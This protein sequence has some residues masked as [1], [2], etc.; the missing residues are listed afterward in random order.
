MT[1]TTI[2]LIV[3]LPFSA[4]ACERYLAIFMPFRYK[5]WATP[6]KVRLVLLLCLLYPI[7]LL[8]PPMATRNTWQ[9]TL[10]CLVIA[11]YPPWLMDIIVG[12]VFIC[13]VIMMI[14]YIQII[15]MSMHLHTQASKHVKVRL[16]VVVSCDGRVLYYRSGVESNIT[17]FSSSV[18]VSDV[19]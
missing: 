5:R 7:V 3:Y 13:I 2:W 6:A 8:V 14:T 10:P 12:N 4:I 15:K 9:A 1:F 19:K 16:K 11:I 17:A 18:C